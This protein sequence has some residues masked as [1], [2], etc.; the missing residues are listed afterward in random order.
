MTHGFSFRPQLSHD[1][2]YQLIRANYLITNGR[3]PTG[4]T[5]VNIIKSV[6]RH[7]ESL[8]IIDTV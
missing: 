2:V 8:F 6:R 7:Y 1:P 3:R 4:N 5:A